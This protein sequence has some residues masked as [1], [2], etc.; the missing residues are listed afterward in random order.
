MSSPLYNKK[1]LK[2]IICVASV[3]FDK[4]MVKKVFYDYDNLCSLTKFILFFILNSKKGTQ[5]IV[6]CATKTIFSY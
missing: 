1:M 4:Y 2:K 3:F 6:L 5:Y